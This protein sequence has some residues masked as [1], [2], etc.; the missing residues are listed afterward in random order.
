M[1]VVDLGELFLWG[2]SADFVENI[3]IASFDDDVVI[4]SDATTE[5]DGTS[6]YDLGTVRNG[7]D[8]EKNS[9]TNVTYDTYKTAYYGR[10]VDQT[11]NYLSADSTG[12]AIKG[13]GIAD[14]GY[15]SYIFKTYSD[16][17]SIYFDPGS[18]LDKDYT[19]LTSASDIFLNNS[20]S[21]PFI[22]YSHSLSTNDYFMSDGSWNGVD[23]GTT[24]ADACAVGSKQDVI[25]VCTPAKEVYFSVEDDYLENITY[26]TDEN[27][28]LMVGSGTVTYANVDFADGNDALKEKTFESEIS[29]V[30]ITVSTTTTSDVSTSTTSGTTSSY[31][32]S[33]SVNVSITEGSSVIDS[34]ETTVGVEAVAEITASVAATY[35]EEIETAFESAW[36]ATDE[37][38]FS[39]TSTESLGNTSYKAVEVTFDSSDSTETDEDGNTYL[40][41][42][43]TYE[44]N[45]GED[46]MT[47]VDLYTGVSYTI[48]LKQVDSTIS[49]TVSGTY[50]ISGT[51]NAVIYNYESVT[52]SHT[53]D[54][55]YASAS[56][57]QGSSAEI[58]E[59]ADN[60]DAAAVL[61]YE[62]D[63][64][65]F[66]SGMAEFTGTATGSTSVSTNF[67]VVVYET[68]SDDLDDDDALS[69][70]KSARNLDISNTLGDDDTLVKPESRALVFRAS[71]SSL[72]R[73]NT[74]GD[75]VQYDLGLVNRYEKTNVG[76]WL[77]TS[78]NDGDSVTVTGANSSNNI[79]ISDSS[80]NYRF[81]KFKTSLLYGNDDDGIYKLNKASKGNT[82]QSMGG[83]DKII[84]SARTTADLGDGDDLYKIKDGSNHLIKTGNGADKVVI[85]DIE[86]YNQ[87][88][89][90]QIS[91]FTPFEDSVTF[92]GNYDKSLIS[93]ELV[94]MPG[95]A[96]KNKYDLTALDYGIDLKYDDEII[97][98]I[99][100]DMSSDSG[101]MNFFRGNRGGL[102]DLALLNTKKLNTLE[103][104]QKIGTGQNITALELL[105]TFVETRGIV[106]TA[107][108]KPSSWSD[109]SASE[110]NTIRKKAW[111]ALGSEVSNAEWN[112]FYSGLLPTVN[113]K[114]FNIGSF[115]KHGS[116]FSELS[117]DILSLFD[118]LI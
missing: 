106:N 84:S 112:Q 74:L 73:T 28:G 51:P 66:S 111:K 37:V 33:Q 41:A 79:A 14:H 55:E 61:G 78:S 36:E 32:G 83:D 19:N 25:Q 42:T 94:L 97:G 75:V 95:S 26:I 29:D 53:S 108:I 48:A 27:G 6:P 60:Y 5:T 72:G 4:N 15:S 44:N 7:Y 80:G 24:D 12:N 98:K 69:S 9:K 82:I 64:F 34:V 52:G 10:S 114:D 62:D 3:S 50:Q 117:S 86:N 92:K 99:Y 107:H 58:L 20:S 81:R 76:F 18:F 35:S 13:D 89:I 101:F 91:D 68:D 57:Y 96:D 67:F 16:K 100:L 11:S 46:V 113:N 45:D 47:E 70:S 93:T 105:E 1:S 23:D 8:Y 21:D 102:V 2:S 116:E 103:I 87:N 39:E 40:D 85:K 56:L 43:Y 90:F 38:S 115:V 63:A 65:D 59:M 110:R 118:G 22:L 88:H 49:N 54:P 104:L 71:A 17:T 30:E 77:N 31:S 109:L